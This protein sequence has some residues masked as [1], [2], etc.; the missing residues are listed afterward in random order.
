VAPLLIEPRQ[1]RVPA[2]PRL[3]W[4]IPSR[5]R[6][7]FDAG[8]DAG[9]SFGVVQ[10]IDGVTLAELALEQV[11]GEDGQHCGRYLRHHASRQ[12]FPKAGPTCSRV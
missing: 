11:R 5:S 4:P 12:P 1:T 10:L 2:W 6:T 8:T 3:G 7:F 9:V